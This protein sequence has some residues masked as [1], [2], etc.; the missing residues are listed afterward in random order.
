MLVTM[1]MR[2]PP[3]LRMCGITSFTS[4]IAPNTFISKSAAH[5]ASSFSMNV[6]RLEVPALFT[7]MSMRPNC[8]AVA[9][10]RRVT[11][12]GLL[13]SHGTPITSGLTLFSSATA[14]STAAGRREQIATLA[15]SW[16]STFAVSFPIPSV[17]PVMIAT[18]P[19]SP[20]SIAFS[21]SVPA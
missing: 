13:T 7:R 9:S 21:F 2:P 16:A 10:T 1:M 5:T 3:T 4:R 14:A 15:P 18:F 20:S 8:L 17:P 11:S 6:P 19:L 12:S